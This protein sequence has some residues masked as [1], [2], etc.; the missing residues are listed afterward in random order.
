MLKVKSFGYQLI[1]D[2]LIH[3]LLVFTNGMFIANLIIFGACMWRCVF[4]YILLSSF[5]MKTNFFY[6][7]HRHFFG[8]FNYY[9]FVGVNAFFA[10]LPLVFLPKRIALTHVI[11]MYGVVSVDKLNLVQKHRLTRN[12][13]LLRIFLKDCVVKI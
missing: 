1:K 11:Y 3:Y 13:H 6:N 7:A 8:H 10:S 12:L 2:S 9:F 4:I 5:E